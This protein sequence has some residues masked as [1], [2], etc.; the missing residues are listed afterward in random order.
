M[1]KTQIKIEHVK[2][3]SL[4]PFAGNPRNNSRAV[5][6]IQQSIEHFGFLNPIIARKSDNMIIAG[7][8]RWK[9]AGQKG[10]TTVP[11]VFVDL[12]DNDAKLYNLADNK[13]GELAEWDDELL[14]EMVQELKDSE[15]DIDVTGFTAEELSILDGTSIGDELIDEEEEELRA[16]KKA[17]ILLSFPPEL[18]PKISDKINEIKKIEGVEYEQCSN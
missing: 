13:L 17:H 5:A 1:S 8:T 7:H 11:V 12:S 16:Y 15:I 14:K 6:P 4:K 10:M 9:A 3:S 18:F 2:T